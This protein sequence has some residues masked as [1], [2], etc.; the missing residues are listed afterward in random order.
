MP[1]DKEPVLV[2]IP[3][4]ELARLERLLDEMKKPGRRRMPGY[5]GQKM[6]V[7][8][9]LVRLALERAAQVEQELAASATVETMPKTPAPT[10]R[11]PKSTKSAEPV[12]APKKRGPKPGSG[13]KEN[14]TLSLDKRV[15]NWL[16]EQPDGPSLTANAIL[17]RS[18]QRRSPPK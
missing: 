9:L 6:T 8:R 12:V 15:V 5:V 2:V 4:E 18:V 7:N 1:T 10:K 3:P 11:T 16:K 14:I 17:A 13:S